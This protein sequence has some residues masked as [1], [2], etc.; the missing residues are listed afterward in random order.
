MSYF[1]LKFEKAGDRSANEQA[2]IQSDSIL[3]ARDKADEIADASGGGN[4]VL[5]LFDEKGLVSTRS[6]RGLWTA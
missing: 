4:A 2:M 5:Q 6:A 1:L 3:L